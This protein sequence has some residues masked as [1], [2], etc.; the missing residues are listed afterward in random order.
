[1]RRLLKLSLIPLGLLYLTICSH[2]EDEPSP[3]VHNQ[4]DVMKRDAPGHGTE[5]K[6]PQKLK[7]C[8]VICGVF[9]E[10]SF[11]YEHEENFK[12]PAGVLHCIVGCPYLNCL[13][14]QTT[15]KSLQLDK[16]T[17]NVTI[18]NISSEFQEDQSTMLTMHLIEHNESVPFSPKR[19]DLL[20]LG[21]LA[22]NWKCFDTLLSYIDFSNSIVRNLP[23]NIMEV[24]KELSDMHQQQ[25]RGLLLWNWWETE[26]SYMQ[27]NCFIFPKNLLNLNSLIIYQDVLLQIPQNVVENVCKRS[28]I[29]KNLNLKVAGCY[30]TQPKG[31]PPSLRKNIWPKLEYLELQLS[32]LTEQ[33]LIDLNM[34]LPSLKYLKLYLIWNCETKKSNHLPKVISTFN[35]DSLHWKT[36]IVLVCYSGKH[37]SKLKEKD[38]MPSRSAT[39]DFRSNPTTSNIVPATKVPLQV[40]MYKENQHPFVVYINMSN[41]EVENFDGITFSMH[42]HYISLNVSHNNIASTN[43]YK[44]FVPTFQEP[45]VKVLDLSY[46]KLKE[47]T[48]NDFLLFKQLNELY[49]SHNEY[50]FIPYHFVSKQDVSRLGWHPEEGWLGAG[51][52]EKLSVSDLYELR[53]LDLSHNKIHQV[54]DLYENV[55]EPS[56]LPIR[57]LF[58]Q[59]NQ[60]IKLPDIVFNNRYI[61]VADFS[62]NNITFD[63]FVETINKLDFD[64]LD[65]MPNNVMTKLVLDYNKME[66]LDLSLFTIDGTLNAVK[67]LMNFNVHMHHN[68]I[69]CNCTTYQFYTNLALLEEMIS[70]GPKYLNIT[71]YQMSIDFYHNQAECAEPHKFAGRPLM[72]IPQYE[73]RECFEETEECPKGCICYN[74]YYQVKYNVNPGIIVNC[75]GLNLTEMPQSVPHETKQLLLGKNKIISMSKKEYMQTISVVDL[76]KNEISSISNDFLSEDLGNSLTSIDISSNKIARLPKSIRDI[77]KTKFDINYNIFLCDCKTLWMKDWLMKSNKYIKDWD[78]IRCFSGPRKGSSIVALTP[79]NC[80]GK[81]SVPEDKV[82]HIVTGIVSVFV[83]GIILGVVVFWYRGEIKVWLYARYRWHPWDKGDDDITNKDYDAFVSY[84]QS[85]VTWVRNELMPFLESEKNQFQLCVH[86]R[87][88]VPGVTITKNIMTAIDCSRRTILV[89]SREFLKSEW[90]HLEFQAAHQKALQDRSNYLIVILLEDINPKD[91]DGSLKLYMKTNTYVNAEDAWFERKLLYA[92]PEKSIAALRNEVRVATKPLVLKV[93]A[94]DTEDGENVHEFLESIKSTASYGT[95]EDESENGDSGAFSET[96]FGSI[97]AEHS[98][99]TQSGLENSL[100][101][102]GNYARESQRA[103]RRKN[104]KHRRSMVR[105]LPPLF[106]RLLNYEHLEE[107]CE[108]VEGG[109]IMIHD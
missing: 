30:T 46:N 50:T 67:L 74:G 86:V 12:N 33:S 32:N 36:G 5:R 92:M 90:C 27:S 64:W 13:S 44:R 81:K 8:S 83:V 97:E 70:T 58:F 29:L 25:D 10:N 15:I 80:G 4:M 71:Q 78:S 39:L 1:M 95:W 102:S 76:S 47:N 48:W 52:R 72:T 7:Q 109:Y 37:D 28:C 24:E 22:C 73:F 17:G 26:E 61:S 62:H 31:I 34:S 2:G 14:C 53:I 103:A 85:D 16:L 65:S 49:L 84:S 108:E 51:G 94:E 19:V 23:S 38:I 59:H 60:I 18:L 42:A 11:L 89:L 101:R 99:S 68:P 100:I 40:Y 87:D 57:A 77:N 69:I 104:K 56:L 98:E 66:V 55:H 79:E 82:I 105:N 75:T 96:T 41:K 35:W 43:L 20:V 107:S 63:K 106:R 21:N 45:P 93:E 88:F 3:G 9:D 6:S 91:L 54:T